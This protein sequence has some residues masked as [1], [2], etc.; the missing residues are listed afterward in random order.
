MGNRRYGMYRSFDEDGGGSRCGVSGPKAGPTSWSSSTI[1]KGA[2]ENMDGN[3][4]LLLGSP[5]GI[6]MGV[7]WGADW[8]S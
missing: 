2:M 7:G 3:L 4:C 5:F 1:E 8:D 6:R